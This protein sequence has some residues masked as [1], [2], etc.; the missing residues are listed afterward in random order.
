[1]KIQKSLFASRIARFASLAAFLLLATLISACVGVPRAAWGG[2][3]RPADPVPFHSEVITGTLQS[4]LRYFIM[5]NDMPEG[6]AFVRLVVNAGSLREEEHEQGLAH[7]V[8]H[9]AF[10]GTERFPDNEVVE[11]LQS[12]GV[13]FGAELNA[14]INHERTQYFINVAV[15]TAADGTRVIPATVLDI[16]DDWTRA[17]VFDQE[18]FENERLVIIE[19]WRGR[20]TANQR[21]F[22]AW[23]GNLLAGS[24]WPYRWA[25]GDIDVIETAPIE[26]LIAFYEKWYQADNMALIFVGDFDGPALQA[27]LESHFR[28]AAPATPTPPPNF[29]LPGPSV[30][31]AAHVILDPEW[32][33]TNV[34]MNFRRPAEARSTTL[35]GFRESL[36]DNLVQRMVDSRFSDAALDPDAPFMGIWNYHSRFGRDARF[37]TLEATARIGQAED[38]IV[39][40]LSEKEVIRRH[41]FHQ[42]EL[43]IAKAALIS[44]LETQATARVQSVIFANQ[45]MEHWLFGGSMPDIAWQ[46]NAARQLLPNI[47][48]ADANSVARSYFA[49]ND[50][51]TF[52]IANTNQVNN[53]PT[54]A[55]ITQ[56]VAQR[57]NLPAAAP[58]AIVM[59][60]SFLQH[61]AQPPARGS[62][63]SEEFDQAANATVWTLSNGARVVLQTTANQNDQIVLH[64]RARGGHSSASDADAMSARLSAMLAGESGIGPYALADVRRS[65]AARQATLSRTL[66]F[67]DRGFTGTSTTGDLQTLLE[68]LHLSFIDTRINADA[69][70]RHMAA[71]RTSLSQRHLNPQNV[72]NDAIVNV[73]TGGHPRLQNIQLEDLDRVNM[74]A[75]LAFQQRGLNP[76]DYTFAFIGNLTPDMMRD[77]VERYIASIPRRAESFN[78]WTNLNVARPGRVERTVHAGIE[79]VAQVR[80]EWYV[81]GPAFNEQLNVVHMVL[82]SYLNTVLFDEIRNNMGGVYSIGSSIG[83]NIGPQ[84]EVSLLIHFACDP[85]RVEEITAAVLALLNRTVASLT[86]AAFNSS[87]AGSRTGWNTNMQNNVWLAAMHSSSLVLLDSPLARVGAMRPQLIDAVTPAML[88]QE[89]ARI[90]PTGHARIVWLSAAGA[91]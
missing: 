34:I 26:Y 75:A 90:L 52:V 59:I 43:E 69:F 39:A 16:V 73:G 11:F 1:M 13:R 19:E 72:F 23:W 63:V 6:R 27:S 88:Q 46:L 71:Q 28:I 85:D 5:E 51:Q 77:Y 25:M 49:S 56:H 82:N 21:V 60:D 83:F 29:P 58:Q 55:S 8:E 40:L 10:R 68:M 20:L 45:I 22:E 87:V 33:N 67:Y 17:L 48:V 57:A 70:A 74:E 89:L 4:G 9:M 36:I 2:L 91:Q 3:G 24:M 12:I 84:S 79:N 50:I 44:D 66:G 61:L 15:E 18:A 30:T 35:G 37:W 64:A 14:N 53:L 62:I 7:F 41:G 65:L 81:P 38:T 47:T 42:T 78:A 86:P 31:N 54:E 76:A 32:P 80:M